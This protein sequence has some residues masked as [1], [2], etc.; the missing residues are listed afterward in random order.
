M[1]E[2]PTPEEETA[3]EEAEMDARRAA[4][5]AAQAQWWI[6]TRKPWRQRETFSVAELTRALV[7][8]PVQA[9]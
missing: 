2:P 4:W 9:K 8:R 7:L 3:R 1:E 6:E 5:R